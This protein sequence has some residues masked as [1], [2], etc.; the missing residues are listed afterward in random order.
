MRGHFTA[1]SLQTTQ[2]VVSGSA[3]LRSK[4]FTVEGFRPGIR[5][6][7]AQAIDVLRHQFGLPAH[8]WSGIRVE[9]ALHEPQGAAGVR[10]VHLTVDVFRRA[11]FQGTRA[12]V[13]GRDQALDGGVDKRPF[14]GREVSRLVG[15]FTRRWLGWC[16]LRRL[17]CCHQHRAAKAGAGNRDHRD[18]GQGFA[19]KVTPGVVLILIRHGGT[20]SCGHGFI[21]RFWELRDVWQASGV[22]RTGKQ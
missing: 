2:H 22:S 15:L 21:R 8:L 11:G 3:V 18:Q 7:N 5:R 16:G 17:R 12:L 6:G 4:S 10:G 20:S 9:R 1:A 14:L 13:I 19:Q